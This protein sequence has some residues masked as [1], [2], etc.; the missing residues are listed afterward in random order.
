[1]NRLS[2]K[3][4]LVLMVVVL[5]I[6]LVASALYGIGNSRQASATL[7]ALYNDR[8]VPLQQLKDVADGYAV[9]IV[10]AAHKTRDGAFSAADG[11]KAI[12]QARA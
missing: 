2:I 1:M 5:L 10:D 12:T 4:R 9:G 3:G 7:G 8:V 11:I 6:L